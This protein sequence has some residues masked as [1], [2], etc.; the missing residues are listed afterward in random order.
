MTCPCATFLASPVGSSTVSD[1][2]A[3][4]IAVARGGN[5]ATIEADPFRT[6][7]RGGAAGDVR[8]GDLRSGSEVYF[9]GRE[10]PA[11]G[12]GGFWS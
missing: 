7:I 11:R 5:P 6:L 10:Q 2:G 12:G 3:A 4:H 8:G 1:E 9:R